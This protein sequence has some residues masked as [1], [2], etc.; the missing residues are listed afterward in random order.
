MLLRCKLHGKVFE[1]RDLRELM[2]KANDEKSGDQL[3]GVAASSALERAAARYVLGEVP[4]WALRDSPAVPYDAD[5]V[6]RVIDDALDPTVYAE[7][8]DWPVGELREWLLRD[9]TEP[10]PGPGQRAAARGDASEFHARPG[11][12]TRVAPAAQPPH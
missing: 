11:R 9:T 3:A 7:I 8:R 2:G 12:H 1:F 6:T 5:E 4:L 10:R